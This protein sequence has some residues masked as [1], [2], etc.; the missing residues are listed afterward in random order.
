MKIQNSPTTP[1]RRPIYEEVSFDKLFSLPQEERTQW[2]DQE[3]ARVQADL[4]A[5]RQLESR[6]H[7]RAKIGMATLFSGLAGS[8]MRPLVE[9][10][11]MAMPLMVASLGATAVGLAV[12]SHALYQRDITC[13]DPIAR[14]RTDA[15]ILGSIKEHQD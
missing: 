13:S 6:A 11:T 15:E 7:E 5:F 14:L 10:T 12:F 2:V 9:G 8:V 3:L 4:S 1:P